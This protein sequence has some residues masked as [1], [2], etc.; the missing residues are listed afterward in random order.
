MY[1]SF[2]ALSQNN[3][4]KSDRNNLYEEFIADLGK[5]KNLSKEQRESISLCCLES[6]TNKFTKEVYFSKIDAELSRIQAS[7]IDQCSKNIG[8]DLKLSTEINSD[9][10]QINT[11]ESD[12]TK[13][14]KSALVK[15]VMKELEKFNITQN[16]KETIALCFVD[17]TC[18]NFTKSQF[19]NLIQLEMDRYI[20]TTIERCSKK[21]NIDLNGKPEK[22][23]NPI[24]FSKSSLF[25]TWNSDQGFTITFNEDGT[26]VKIYKTDF[27]IASRYT[28]IEN[29][30]I[31]GDWFL[32]ED[33]NLTLVENWVELEFKL[34]KTKR[35][36]YSER[37]NYRITN[38]TED[39]FKL[40][41]VNGVTCCQESGRSQI[42]SIQANRSK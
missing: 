38:L 21:N 41:F 29:S 5:Y 18:E 37:S 8:V 10:N 22:E 13:E 24:K 30:K 27:I 12:W 34:F 35:Y 11:I 19:N 15:Q 14:D 40:Q 7:T 3:W 1:S 33:G 25:G 42:Q 32:D 17:E 23:N 4:T 28:R 2:L 36:S 20:N 16:H 31:T 9:N 26:F 39:F 6:I